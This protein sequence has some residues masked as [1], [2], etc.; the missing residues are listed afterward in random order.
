[1]VVLH[2]LSNPAL[3]ATLALFLSAI[4]MVRDP[5]DRT[6][7]ILVFALVLNLFYGVLF[8]IFMERADSLFPWKYDHALFRMDEALGLHAAWIAGPLQGTLRVPLWVVYQSMIPM[9]I[10]WLLV[11]RYCNHRGSVVPAYAAELAAGPVLYMLLPACGPIYAFGTEWLHPPAVSAA[12]IR[13]NGV[14]NAFPSLHVG[15]AFVFVLFAPGRLWRGVAL[16]FLAATCMATLSTGEHY[17]I[18]LI[19]GLAFGTFAASVGLSRY[20]RA[21][22]FLGIACC[23]SLAVR[24]ESDFLIAYPL[25]TRFCAAITIMLTGLTVIWEW[26][27]VTPT[28]SNTAVTVGEPHAQALTPLDDIQY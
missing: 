13:L 27:I 17:V 21:L 18:D 2:V 19:P 28:E 25:V 7:P 22:A 26:N 10:C 9:M 3:V 23:W 24:L 1:L 6:R 11:T 15:T 20:R 5:K 8:N 12:A 14:P 4:W 16:I